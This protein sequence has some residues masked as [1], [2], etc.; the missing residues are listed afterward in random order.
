[1]VK[2][3]TFT[4]L[5]VFVFLFS[6]CLTN[7]QHGFANNPRHILIYENRAEVIDQYRISGFQIIETYESFFLTQINDQQETFLKKNKVRFTYISGIGSLRFGGYE[8]KPDTQK[9]IIYPQALKGSIGVYAPEDEAIFLLQFVGPIKNEWITELNPNEYTLFPVADFGYLVKTTGSLAQT[10][11]EKSYV[12]MVGYLPPVL[13]ISPE[14][15]AIGSSVVDLALITSHDFVLHHFLNNHQIDTKLATFSKIGS[16]GFLEL[17]SQHTNRLG[18]YSLNS[19]IISITQKAEAK[20]FNAEAAQVVNIR[21]NLHN[22]KQLGLTGEGQIVAV[23]DSGLS[24]GDELTL[25]NAFKDPGKIVAHHS[26]DSNWSDSGAHGNLHGTHVAGTIA[27]NDPDN[28]QYRGMAYKANL[29]IQKMYFSSGPPQNLPPAGPNHSLIEYFNLAYNSGARIHSNSWGNANSN[30][31]AS[32]AVVM[33]TFLWERKDFSIL[34]ASGNYQTGVYSFGY[35]ANAKNN[36]VVGAT[37]NNKAGLN[38]DK[39]ASFSV[40]GPAGDGRI[41]PDIVAPGQ[42]VRSTVDPNAYTNKSGTS[43]ATPVT[44]GSLALLRQKYG[45]VSAALLKAL[46]IHGAKSNGLVNQNN[47]PVSCPNSALGW[48]RVDVEKSTEPGINYWD[49]TGTNGLMTG[50]TYSVNIEVYDSTKP[51]KVNLVYTDAPGTPGASK[52]LVNDLNLVV[53]DPLGNVYRGNHFNNNGVSIT[54]AVIADDLNN[55]EGVFIA[56]PET[57]MYQVEVVALSVPQGE[58]A[59]GRQ[60]FAL[61]ASGSFED[62]GP[63]PEPVI[64]SY[65]LEVVPFNR[66]VVQGDST[67]Y[68]ANL[69]SL[70]GARGWVELKPLQFGGGFGD[71]SNVGI[72]YDFYPS[73][74]V[75]LSAGMSASIMIRVNTSDDTPLSSYPMTVIS[76][77][78]EESRAEIVL[79]GNYANFNMDLI[80]EPIFNLSLRPNHATIYQDESTYT[81]VT[82][83]PRFE[84]NEQVDFE[85]MGLPPNTTYTMDP[86]PTSSSVIHE[87][88]SI[89]TI[90]TEKTTP[91]GIYDVSIVGSA[92]LPS[93]KYIERKI[94][95][96]LEVLPRISQ[97]KVE[98]YRRSFPDSVQAPCKENDSSNV[99]VKYRIQIKNIGNEKLSRNRIE[100]RLDP[101][102]EL[103][104]SEPSGYF[105]DG[106]L[107]IDLYDLNEPLNSRPGDCWPSRDCNSIGYP[108]FSDNDGHYLVIYARLSKTA[109][110]V[111]SSTLLENRLTFISDPN[112][113][114]SFPFYT[115]LHPCPGAENPLYFRAYVEN[116]N[117]DGTISLNSEVRVRFKIE[118]GSGNYTFTWNWSDGTVLNDQALDSNEVVLKHTY[119]KAGIYRVLI[120]AKDSNGRFKKGEIILRVK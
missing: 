9:N 41:K 63:D 38:P 17:K 5:M 36:I 104:S 29:V 55:V 10:L 32:D 23:L 78:R 69:K 61:V 54:P 111:S 91:D 112:Y 98:V 64:P 115:M 14:L 84:F 27:G 49:V 99:V 93:G 37:E 34:F 1:M 74:R 73:N 106:I 33:D 13:K 47:Q 4:L 119:Q 102:L 42:Q 108:G 82:V 35:Q 22:D 28:Q 11:R 19:K 26:A 31:Y 100:V 45:N 79:L 56:D 6:W 16:L 57:G 118:G 70:N 113:S 71:P 68:Q 81:Q 105:T 65:S 67:N 8:F 62:P 20:L 24:T 12:S 109:I 48:G 30:T 116:L 44:S 83:Q 60:P 2:N 101:N 53:R 85:V 86:N 3:R 46:L 18:A 97:H 77:L 52:A 87:Y 50:D 51:L 114:E 66:V 117:P 7:I 39:L 58:P 15:Q 94:V 110:Q 40:R 107:K 96:R 95:F 89:L 21:D 120:Q 59:T 90:K 25:H 43:M 92:E 76:E 72:F 88:R 80:Q 75:Y 103:I